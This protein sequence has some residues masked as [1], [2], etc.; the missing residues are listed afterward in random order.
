[1]RPARFVAF[2]GVAT[3][4]IAV[5]SCG[6]T[7]TDHTDQ[8]AAVYSALLDS[9]FNQRP[10]TSNRAIVLHDHTVR[11]GT[12]GSA[13]TPADSIAVAGS[14]LESHFRERSEHI[15][16]L[17]ATIAKL[18]TRRRVIAIDSLQHESIVRERDSLLNM[19]PNQPFERVD[20]YWRRFFAR[21][22]NT[23]GST[24]VTSVGYNNTGDRAV[25]YVWHG[26]GGLCGEGNWVL[27]QRTGNKWR[28]I[29]ISQTTVH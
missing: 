26:C 6:P 16:S 12:T 2:L 5:A 23:F 19:P 1:M 7:S 13:W 14:D 25:V 24:S 20:I 11:F 27:F 17:V 21:F 22:P 29:R 3:L 18:R 10:D 9:L 15:E 4:S 8:D 28:V